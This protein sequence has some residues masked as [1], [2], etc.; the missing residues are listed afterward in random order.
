MVARFQP[1]QQIRRAQFVGERAGA[2]LQFGRGASERITRCRTANTLAISQPCQPVL[3]LLAIVP[4]T[5]RFPGRAEFF[6]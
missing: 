5:Q 6:L 3:E 1:A 2:R 4:L